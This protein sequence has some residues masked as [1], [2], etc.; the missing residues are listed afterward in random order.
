MGCSYGLIDYD[1]ELWLKEELGAGNFGVVRKAVLRRRD[2]RPA[3]IVAVK[4]LEQGNASE[5]IQEASLMSDIP[6]H[7]HVVQVLFPTDSSRFMSA[8]SLH[9]PNPA[10]CFAWIIL[11]SIK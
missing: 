2:I 3:R 10:A 1:K 4:T 11:S 6:K 5:M 8:A 7:Q 9:E